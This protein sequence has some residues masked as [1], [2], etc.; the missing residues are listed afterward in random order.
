MEEEAELVK[1]NHIRII[2]IATAA[3][4]LISSVVVIGVGI[5]SGW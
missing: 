2:A 5:F 4:F 1:K 3:I